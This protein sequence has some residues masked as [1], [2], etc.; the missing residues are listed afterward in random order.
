MILRHNSVRDLTYELLTEVCK[1]VKLE[2]PLLP[3]SGEELP[4]GANCSDGA[5]SDV[6]ASGFWLPLN[7]AFFDIRVCNPMAQSNYGKEIQTMYKDHENAKKREYN[8]RIIQIEKGSFTP[9]VFSCTGG[10]GGEASRFIQKLA[11]KWSRKKGEEYSKSVSFL[12]K[13]YCFDLIRTC[14]LSFRGE[15]NT[16]KM[17]I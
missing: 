9:V 5:R 17:T 8:S 1:D 12:R 2:P 11:M 3:V 6:S 15:R 16:T 10:A 4:A 7:R 14:V 13:R